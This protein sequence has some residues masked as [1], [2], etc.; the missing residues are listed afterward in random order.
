MHFFLFLLLPDEPSCPSVVGCLV[1]GKGSY[2]SN[3]NI[4][5]K[6]S[7]HSLSRDVSILSHLLFLFARS[8]IHDF[9]KGQRNAPIGA[10]VMLII[11]FV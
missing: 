3:T 4:G 2:T 1:K 5:C 7:E 8:V 10:L 9:L 11:R 6:C